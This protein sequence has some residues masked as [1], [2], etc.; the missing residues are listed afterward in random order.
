MRKNNEVIINDYLSWVSVGHSSETVLSYKYPLKIFTEYLKEKNKKILLLSQEDFTKFAIYLRE[1]RQIKNDTQSGYISVVRCLWDWL[2]KKG[3]VK[4]TYKDIALPKREQTN[5]YPYA[6]KE[7]IDI[8]LKSFNVFF[9]KELRNKCIVS[10]LFNTG[11]RVGELLSLDITDIDIEKKKGIVVT[12]KR[13]NHQRE[14]YW[15]EETNNLLK[16]WL[17][18]RKKIMDRFSNYSNGLFVNFCSWRG[19]KRLKRH[20]IEHIFREKRSELGIKKKISPHSCRHGFGHRALKNNVNLRYTQILL[21]HKKI[22]TTQIYMNC[23]APDVEKV[24]R[25]KMS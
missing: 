10:F 20:A 11:V 23:S 14:I 25:E 4:F 1:Y 24:Y 9:P 8:I 7:E 17:D 12:K 21:G 22:S 18:V 2:Y 13:K 3:L 19:G 5:H 16:N 6:T 15:D